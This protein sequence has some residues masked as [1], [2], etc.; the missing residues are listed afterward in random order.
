M[1]GRKTLTD[2]RCEATLAELQA[3]LVANG[4]IDPGPGAHAA[5]CEHWDRHM[6]PDH[7]NPCLSYPCKSVAVSAV[8]LELLLYAG[9]GES[10]QL[11]DALAAATDEAAAKL[12]RLPVHFAQALQPSQSALRQH[13]RLG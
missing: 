10:L 7:P 4:E 1:K 12:G 13:R 11:L 3:W 9:A 5:A 2:I 8:I 6:L